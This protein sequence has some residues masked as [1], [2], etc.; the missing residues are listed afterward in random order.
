MVN[1]R[2]WYIIE[3][4]ANPSTIKKCYFFTLNSKNSDFKKKISPGGLAPLYPPPYSLS[5]SN[6]APP[7]HKSASCATA[8][9]KGWISNF[10]NSIFSII[11]ICILW[12]M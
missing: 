7:P 3:H 11:M 10:L 2:I 6:F 9:F 8:F 12:Y 1:I 4:R 5:K